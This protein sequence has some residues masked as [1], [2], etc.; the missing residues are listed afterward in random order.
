MQYVAAILETSA[1]CAA[2]IAFVLIT[3]MMFDRCTKDRFVANCSVSGGVT[4]CESSEIRCSLIGIV[5][6]CYTK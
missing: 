2:V 5:L 1:G 3:A 6:E 4:I